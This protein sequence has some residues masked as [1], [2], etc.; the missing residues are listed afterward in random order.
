MSNEADPLAMAGASGA[1]DLPAG[2]PL[3]D[4]LRS[5]C[6]SVEAITPGSNAGVTICNPPRTHL[7]RAIFPSLPRVFGDSIADIPTLAPFFGS[8]AEAVCRGEIV[9][10]ADIASDSRFDPAWRKLCLDSGVRAVQSRP[11]YLR[12]GA[13]YGTFVLGY[14]EPRAESDWDVAVMTFAADAVGNAL[15][16]DLDR[17]K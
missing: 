17:S 3:D 5:L 1:A 10:C 7:Q 16:A 11:I 6:A 9:T 4:R 8:C 14:R 12:D 2:R 13:T 15:Q